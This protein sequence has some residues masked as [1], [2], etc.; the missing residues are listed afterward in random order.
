MTDLARL[1][2]R[3]KTL[4]EECSRLSDIEAIRKLRY[5]YWR[6]IHQG[7]WDD[8]L[9]C[10][11]DN[12]AVDF[13]YGVEL[14]GKAA[15]ERFYKEHMAPAYVLVAPQGHNPEIEIVTQTR[16]RGLWQLDNSM[17]EAATG[18]AVRVGAAYSEEYV[19]ET[20]EWVIAGQKV[21][22]IYR[23]TVKTE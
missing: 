22:H 1:E 8:L 15:L 7:L 3:I 13:G 12:A 5:K 10:Y 17:V 20:G 4:E 11:A 19:K 2:M 9:D 14:E 16:A 18:K 23:Q 21:S 6:C